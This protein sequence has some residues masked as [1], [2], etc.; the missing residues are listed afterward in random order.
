[1]STTWTFVAGGFCG[2]TTRRSLSGPAALAIEIA[3][4]QA[5]PPKNPS[6][7]QVDALIAGATTSRLNLGRLL[8][9]CPTVSQMG[10]GTS[11]EKASVQS[12]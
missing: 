3:S 8:P 6:H 1:M 9:S 7:I 2:N 12:E 5:G 10:W 11:P 4:E